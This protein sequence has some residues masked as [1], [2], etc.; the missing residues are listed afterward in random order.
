MLV[1]FNVGISRSDP[2]D[3]GESDNL[4]LKRRHNIN[5]K[6]TS[7]AEHD[8]TNLRGQLCVVK[9]WHDIALNQYLAVTPLGTTP[10]RCIL[11]PELLWVQPQR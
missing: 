1:V 2:E 11:I 4:V 5:F 9:H 6:A 8:S 3:L 7:I 10:R